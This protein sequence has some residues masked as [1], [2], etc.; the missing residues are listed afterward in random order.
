MTKNTTKIQILVASPSDVMDERNALSA[1]IEQLNIELSQR[2]DVL[3]D[4][5]KWETHTAP[6][7]GKDP[8]A[9]INRQI[10]NDYDILILILWARIGTKTP[11]AISGTIEEFEN[12]YL[13]YQKNPT[14]V[15]IMVYFKT[16]PVSL[17]K[18]DPE[19]LMSVNK[20]KDSLSSKGIYYKSFSTNEEFSSL[21]HE[22]LMKHVFDL[23]QPDTSIIKQV[24]LETNE[25]NLQSIDAKSA[26]DTESLGFLDSIDLT[27]AEAS[28]ATEI[29]QLISRELNI[30]NEKTNSTTEKINKINDSPLDSQRKTAVYQQVINIQAGYMDDFTSSIQPKVSILDESLSNA[31]GATGQTFS[32]YSDF[33]NNEENKQQISDS[34]YAI[35]NLRETMVEGKA[36]FEILRSTIIGLPRL[37]GELIRAKRDQINLIENL[38]KVYEHG[39]TLADEVILKGENLL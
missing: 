23:L 5:I 26:I 36:S 25:Y 11:R 27:V 10:P 13:R 22:N 17:E 16:S 21:L 4:L 39:I 9:I 6:S 32:L 14:S 1:V 15:Q 7:V 24:I 34:V 12:A 37:T 31:L 29:Q 3:L 8:Q 28:R 19:Q 35:K 18:I 30:M 2:F 20:F 33:G 38:I